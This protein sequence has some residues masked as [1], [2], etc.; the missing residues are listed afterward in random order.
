M[1]TITVDKDAF[2]S[3][4]LRL[5]DFWISNSDVFSNVDSISVPLGPD[6]LMY[7]KSSSLYTWLFGYEIPDSVL[8]LCI[9]RSAVPFKCVVHF[10]SG[11]SYA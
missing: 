2:S 9:D 3:R 5:F 7:A 10:L 6:E 11:E 8:V 4:I 1:P